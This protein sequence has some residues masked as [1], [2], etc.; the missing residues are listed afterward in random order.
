MHLIVNRP[1]RPAS[2]APEP[3]TLTLAQPPTPPQPSAGSS[4]MQAILPALGGLGMILF[5]IAGGNPI[6]LLAG[7][8]MLLATVGGGFA[9]FILSRTGARRAFVSARERYVEYLEEVRDQ[10]RAAAAAQ[11]AHTAHAHPDPACLP[12]WVG[13]PRIYERRAADDDFGLVRVGLGRVPH[14]VHVL[15]PKSSSPLDRVDPV[16]LRAMMGLASAYR[17]L[18]EQPLCLP[19]GSAGSIVLTGD[20][21]A[22][23]LGLAR[24]LIVGL[25]ALHS[26]ADLRLAIASPHL[27]RDFAFARWLPHVADPR[28]RDGVLPRVWLAA[29]RQ[30][31]ADELGDHL[32]ELAQEGARARRAGGRHRPRE[33]LVVVLDE[34]HTGPT[35]AFGPALAGGADPDDVGLCVVRLVARAQ[36]EPEDVDARAR[37]AGGRLI[38][39]GPAIPGRLDGAADRVGPADADALARALAP[40]VVSPDAQPDEPL[41]AQAPL[42]LL[43]GVPDVALWTPEAGWRPRS[44]R[45]LLRVAIGVRADGTPLVL[46][47]KE[48]ARDG[49]GPHGLLVGATGS[50]KSELL[51]SLVLAL[52]AS[53]PPED[54][55]FV[56]V[57]FK[58]GAT[59]SGLEHLPHVAGVIT[60]LAGDLG[61]VDRMRDALFGE[62]ARRQELLHEAGH[63]P[64][65]F[66][67]TAAR[68]ADPSLPPLPHLLV[69]VDEFAE[70]LTA[71]PDFL[72]IFTATGRIG[73]SIGVHQLLASQRLDDGRLRGLESFLSYRLALRTFNAEE[74]RAVIGV[75]DAFELPPLP[76]SGYLKVDNSVFERFKAAY[77]SGPY[78][79]STAGPVRARRRVQ[80][81]GATNERPRIAPEGD[82]PGPA[83][84]ASGQPDADEGRAGPSVLDVAVEKMRA[85][86]DRVHQIW[87]PPLPAWLGLADVDGLFPDPPAP[88]HARI[89]IVDLPGRQRQEPLDLDLTGECGHVAILGGPQSGRST[90]LR[91]LALSL[92]RRHRPGQIALHAVDFGGGSLRT[93]ADLPHVGTVAGRLDLDRVRR[94][95]AELV[96][97]LDRRERLFAREGIADAADLRRRFAAGEVPDLAAAD[98]VLLLDDYAPLRTDH[99]LLHD[100]LVALVGRGLAFGIHVALTAARWFDLRPALQTTIPGRLELHLAESMD[101]A[102]DRRLAANIPADVPGRALAGPG[103]LAQ[104]A[105]PVLSPLLPSPGAGGADRSG[106]PHSADVSR[107]H[108]DAVAHIAGTVDGPRVTAI[109]LLP[110]DLR[111]PQLLERPDVEAARVQARAAAARDR[112][113]VPAVLGIAEDTLGPVWLDLSGDDTHLLVFGDATSGKTSLLRS[114]AAQLVADHDDRQVVLTL[115][116]PRRTML[117]EV[118]QDHL[119]AY[120]PNASAAEGLAHSLATEL[121]R[122]QPTSTDPRDLA[123]H[124]WTGP[125]IVCLVDD[126]ELITGPTGNPLSPL[127][128]F[129]PGARDIGFHLVIARHAGGAARALFDPVFQ[130]VK[131]LAAP[132]ILLSG[133]PEEGQLW[134]K[135]P[136]GPLPPG[137][138]QL[139]RRGQRPRL[140]HLA[141]P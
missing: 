130:R 76:G 53:H 139:V 100:Q 110:L 116:D 31:L 89:G 120:A 117:D 50:G 138:A 12:T 90:T 74:S 105:L 96:G 46:D 137:R 95:F 4:V 97:E 108:R 16:C 8:V 63:A 52:A 51:R 102:L 129:L 72:D 70:L 93:L 123:E 9:I 134:P 56:L 68:Q 49:M 6:F 26:P 61:M 125:R 80:F 29:D 106:R 37:D 91:T 22:E 7:M 13:T 92:A 42:D 83:G 64:H 88:L 15:V 45:D 66:A 140:I 18:G 28:A 118:P 43:V 112:G 124:R 21:H 33:R 84:A 39:D 115:V 119:G 114:L 141:R 10:M 1:P 41:V 98:V 60:N 23:A 113:L 5:L 58:G 121:A 27:E 75:P 87:L 14:P 32:R 73:R 128:P 133:D 77:V 65:L 79:R 34:W 103:R 135:A 35:G 20:S 107:A 57:D 94:V 30:T 136:L 47:L 131:E 85:G 48:S 55:A 71:K 81:F 101:S 11:R 36:D 40:R 99:D 86:Q 54:L 59:F 67:Y 62:L 127:L 44:R 132:G 24:S 78:R 19:C 69:I 25:A 2:R 126:A 82:V 3:R 38:L 109:E 104:I 111:L 17:T 122:R